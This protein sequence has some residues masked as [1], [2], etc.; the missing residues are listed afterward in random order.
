MKTFPILLC[1]HASVLTWKAYVEE[2][3]ESKERSKMAALVRW[4]FIVMAEAYL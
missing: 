4:Q 1:Q 3:G 2:F